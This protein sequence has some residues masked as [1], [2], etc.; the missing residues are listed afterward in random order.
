MLLTPYH[1]GAGSLHTY[2]CVL[3]ALLAAVEEC[4]FQLPELFF[5]LRQLVVAVHL[6]VVAQV[7]PLPIRHCYPGQ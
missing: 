6:N 7:D 2:D 4:F 5:F 3:L 1:V